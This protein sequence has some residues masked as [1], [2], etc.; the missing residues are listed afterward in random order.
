MRKK[1]DAHRG[2]KHLGGDLYL[3][4]IQRTDPKTG[5]PLDVRRKRHCPSMKAAVVEQA[6]LLAEVEGAAER[7]PIPRLG[8]YARSWLKA[9]LDTL[10]PSTQKRYADTLELHILPTLGSIYLDRL[11]PEDILAWFEQTTQTKAPST[12]NSHLNLLRTLLADATAQYRLP[13][14]PIARIR[15]VPLR[16]G[17]QADSDEP[18][19]MLTSEEIGRFLAV[20]KVRYPQWFPLVFTQFATARR[21]G[22][23][24]ALHWEDIDIARSQ[25]IIRRAHWRG[26]VGTPKTDRVVKVPLTDELRRVL[27]DWRQELLRTQHR[28]MHTGLVFPSQAGKP[29]QNAS[30]LA[31]PFADC[32]AEIGVSRGFSSHG[33]RRT[34]NNLLRQVTTS[35]VTRAITGH[36]TAAMTEHYSHIAA[37][38]KYTAATHMLALVLPEKPPSTPNGTPACTRSR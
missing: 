8:D 12:A 28:H 4:R 33:L 21:F 32:L 36:V 34:A 16:R 6:R 11:D 18:E 13:F 10:K 15:T 29:H 26:I 30:C 9:R 1:T 3:I 14:N 25:I 7:P 37:D 2:I 31:K 35:E 5:L 20:F 17:A 38:E 22:E 27:D 23:V 19:N 24:S